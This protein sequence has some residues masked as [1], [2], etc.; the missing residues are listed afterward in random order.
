MPSKE[1]EDILELLNSM[2]DTS[3]LTF[4]EGRSN[5]EEQASQLPVAENVSCEPLS[6][7]NIP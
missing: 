3:G 2:P 4:G 5:F 7:G 1:Y 6:V